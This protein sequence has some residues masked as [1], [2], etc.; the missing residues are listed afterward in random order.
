VRALGHEFLKRIFRSA[1][2]LSVGLGVIVAFYFGWRTGV[3][4]GVAAL[5]GTLNLRFIQMLVVEAARPQ[6]VH[7]GRVGLAALLKFPLLYGAGFLFV[8]LA[9]PGPVA[10]LGGLT[11]IYVVIL[12]KFLGRAMVDSAWFSGPVARGE[13]GR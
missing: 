12:L 13:R 7:W 11:L 3:D 5:W 9:H 10:L 8:V 2:I 1:T 4:F 6:G